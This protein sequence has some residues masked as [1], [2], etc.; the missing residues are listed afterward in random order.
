MLVTS[1]CLF[2]YVFV[3]SHSTGHNSRMIFKLHIQVGTSLGKT[4]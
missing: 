3:C 2:V 1:V 4:Y